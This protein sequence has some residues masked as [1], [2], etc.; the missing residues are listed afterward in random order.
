MAARGAERPLVEV[1]SPYFTTYSV[2]PEAETRRYV[3][4]LEAFYRLLA[5][6]T[7]T[8]QQGNAGPLRV[9]LLGRAEVAHLY[10]GISYELGGWVSQDGVG[11]DVVM[12]VPADRNQD[13]RLPFTMIGQ[14]IALT[15]CLGGCMPWFD[16]GLAEFA[17]T[18]WF[19]PDRIEFR[20]RPERIELLLAPKWIPAEEFFTVPYE[21]PAY[22][23]RRMPDGFAAQAWLMMHYVYVGDPQVVRKLAMYGASVNRGTEPSAALLSALGTTYAELDKTLRAYADGKRYTNLTLRPH[24][25]PESQIKV[26]KL[27]RAQSARVLLELTM[28]SAEPYQQKKELENLFAG[29]PEEPW[30]LADSAQILTD[31]FRSREA[32]IEA[33]TVSW[34]GWRSFRSS[35][36]PMSRRDW[37]RR[38]STWVRPMRGTS[39]GLPE[40]RTARR[41]ARPAR[42]SSAR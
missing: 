22:V 9:H 2:L 14:R 30:L 28:R 11:A 34:R 23:E 42:I 18:A 24:P 19:Y 12:V 16:V 33:W 41:C 8:M 5:A 10:G 31:H 26:R 6:A 21:K 20:A 32:R 13:Y 17:S 25:L 1:V 37:L 29:L 39:R 4:G 35:R 40:W 3:A 7:G 38:I 36:M 27:D 15:H